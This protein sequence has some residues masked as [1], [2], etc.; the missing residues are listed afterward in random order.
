MRTPSFS[1]ERRRIE[2]EEEGIEER[3]GIEGILRRIVVG[4]LLHRSNRRR[5]C[6]DYTCISSIVDDERNKEKFEILSSRVFA[7]EDGAD[8]RLTKMTL[9]SEGNEKS[10]PKLQKK[11]E[12]DHF[13]TSTI[14]NFETRRGER[15]EVRDYKK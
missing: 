5:C 11:E 13:D 6:N 15:G 4:E 1:S 12:N 10:Y 8:G 3:E 9:L 2:E 14:L 7:R